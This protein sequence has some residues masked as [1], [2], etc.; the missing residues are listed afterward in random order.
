[1][2]EEKWLDCRRGQ[3]CSADDEASRAEEPIEKG[4]HGH[5]ICE[6]RTSPHSVVLEEQTSHIGAR[7]GTKQKTHGTDVEKALDPC[8]HYVPSELPI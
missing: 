8:N 3:E 6:E 7:K 1:L 4:C 2:R 5:G